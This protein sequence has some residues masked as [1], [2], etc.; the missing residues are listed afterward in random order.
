LDFADLFDR[1]LLLVFYLSQQ[2]AL[3]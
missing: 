1:N 2:F 3:V